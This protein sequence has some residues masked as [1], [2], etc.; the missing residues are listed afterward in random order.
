MWGKCGEYEMRPKALVKLI[1]TS[2]YM[3]GMF[4]FEM[5]PK[6]VGVDF[7]NLF[8][9]ESYIFTLNVTMLL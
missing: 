3:M 1:W 6:R 7:H 9:P 5:E 2:F 8:S 4:W